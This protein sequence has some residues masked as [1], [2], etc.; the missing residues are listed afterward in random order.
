[1]SDVL[2]GYSRSK[3]YLFIQKL[4]SLEK[5]F[6]GDF[7]LLQAYFVFL[8][9][10]CSLLSTFCNTALASLIT[11]HRSLS[12]AVDNGG[13]EFRIVFKLLATKPL[14][15]VQG[16]EEALGARW[17]AEGWVIRKSPTK[18]F[19]LLGSGRCRDVHCDGERLFWTTVSRS[20]KIVHNV[21]SSASTHQ[22]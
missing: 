16:E 6:V 5:A 12:C 10:C 9:N 3:G 17:T 8:H 2:Q 7:S 15:Q 14:F 20:T 1:M 13:L 22:L 18:I 19:S 11:L 21:L 4:Y